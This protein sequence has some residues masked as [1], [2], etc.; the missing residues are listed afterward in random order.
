MVGVVWEQVTDDLARQDDFLPT[1]PF[2]CLY[3]SKADPVPVVGPHSTDQQEDS[4]EQKIHREQGRA[5]GIQ[6]GS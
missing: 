1:G 5:L 4:P 3:G 2:C 6:Y